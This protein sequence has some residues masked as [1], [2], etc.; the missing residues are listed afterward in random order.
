M[1]KFLTFLFS[2][3]IIIIWQEL[4]LS[5]S[6]LSAVIISCDKKYT[7]NHHFFWPLVHN[8]SSFMMTYGSPS[9][10]IW[11]YLQSY[12]FD[13]L[14]TPSH[15]PIVTSSTPLI[16]Y[17]DLQYHYLMLPTGRTPSG[18]IYFNLRFS[19]SHQ[20]LWPLVHLRSLFLLTIICCNL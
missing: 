15:Y 8:Q 19:F 16:I 9:I 5:Y 3:F 14:Y 4:N 20:F 17:C 11:C 18:T 7:F 12:F 2:L 10:I 1:F 6:L 13:L